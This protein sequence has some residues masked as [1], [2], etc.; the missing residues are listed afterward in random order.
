[1]SQQSFS[2]RLPRPVLRYHGGKY[3]LVSWILAHFPPHVHYVEPFGGAGSVLLGKPRV[4]YETFNDIDDEIVNVFLVLRDPVQSVALA[5]LLRLTPFARREFV[6]AYEWTDEPVERARRAIIRSFMA[7]GGGG[8]NREC[9]TGFRGNAARSRRASASDWSTYPDCLPLFTERLKKVEIE[10]CNAFSLF[11]RYDSPSTLFYLD[12]T[13]MEGAR[14]SDSRRRKH[15][16]H[17][18]STSDHVAML[19]IITRL[20]GMVVLSAYPHSR[21]AEALRGWKRIQKTALASGQAK[22]VERQEVLWLSPR[23]FEALE[24]AESA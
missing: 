1:M 12:P 23:A 13:Y 3:R 18:M 9:K 19:E 24:G 8:V 21:Y 6:S 17:D 2:M 10:N 20:K 14:S 4:E 5:E 16:A 15:Y 7:F 22:S 11:R